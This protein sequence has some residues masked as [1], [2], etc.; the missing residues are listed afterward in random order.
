MGNV[1]AT[2]RIGLGRAGDVN[3]GQVSQ[4]ATRP[5][6]V[7]GVTNPL[8]ASGGVDPD[9]TELARRA[10]PLRMLALDRL[11]SV[12]DYEDFARAR[13]GI[14]TASASKLSDGRRQVVHVTVAGTDDVPLDDTSAV[15]TALRA[16]YA[17]NGD[18]H[19][20]VQVAVRALVLLILGAGIHVAPDYQWSLVAPAVRAALLDRFGARRQ[21]LGQPVYLSEVI[22][23][24]Q[25]VPGVDYLEVYTF[26][27]VPGEDTPEQLADLGATLSQADQVV[28]ARLATY[29]GPPY[30]VRAGD[31]LTSVAK[32]NDLTVTELLSLNPGL[33]GTD[34]TAVHSLVVRRDILPAQLVRFDPAV[35]DTIALHEVLP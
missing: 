15:V 22:A 7:T 17:V 8:R 11:L 23:T 21:Q 35:P 32:A 33:T 4:L 26:T 10:T 3:A 25:A 28:L 13:D 16:A 29:P 2:Y 1:T 12:R 27:G 34:L 24:M 14:G 5:Q 19:Q 20:P 31:T 6:G 9:D 18:P 30:Y